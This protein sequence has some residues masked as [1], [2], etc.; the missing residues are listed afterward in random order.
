MRSDIAV[1]IPRN[2]RKGW[3]N[4]QDRRL[5]EL[6]ENGEPASRIADRLGRTKIAVLS[7]LCRPFGMLWRD[8]YTGVYYNGRTAYYDPNVGRMVR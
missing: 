6:F 4:Y 2:H 7:R 1:T 8:Q 3:T 5:L